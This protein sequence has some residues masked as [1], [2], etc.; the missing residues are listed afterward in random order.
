MNL[1]EAIGYQPRQM[2]QGMEREVI[3]GGNLR[4]RYT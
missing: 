2:V 4:S 1:K 3:G